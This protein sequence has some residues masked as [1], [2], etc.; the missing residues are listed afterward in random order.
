[1]AFLYQSNHCSKIRQVSN[2]E[3][4]FLKTCCLTILLLFFFDIQYNFIEYFLELYIKLQIWLGKKQ[5]IFKYFHSNYKILLLV[6]NSNLLLWLLMLLKYFQY[7]IHLFP[8]LCY[9]QCKAQFIQFWSL[10][11]PENVEKLCWT[12][13]R[14][15]SWRMRTHNMDT[16]IRWTSHIDHVAKGELRIVLR[17]KVLIILC[18][19]NL[20]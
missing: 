16:L 1:M 18:E 3:S 10:Y 11:R 5:M 19:R 15:S 6:N 2:R 8:C 12:H 17:N 4:R 9:K 13:T 14:L 7:P 20:L